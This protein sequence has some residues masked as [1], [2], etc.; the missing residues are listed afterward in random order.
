VVVFSVELLD[1]TL[2]NLWLNVPVLV[3]VIRRRAEAGRCTAGL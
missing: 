1:R 2:T 3:T